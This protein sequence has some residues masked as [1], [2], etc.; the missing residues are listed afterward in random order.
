MDDTLLK[1]REVAEQIHASEA[2]VRRLGRAGQ[3]DEVRISPG[4]VRVRA[5]SVARLIAN[6]YT[7]PGPQEAA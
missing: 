1:R 7:A 6:G 5:S 4:V 3:L 2:T